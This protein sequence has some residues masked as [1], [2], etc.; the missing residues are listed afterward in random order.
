MRTE[1]DVILEHTQD[2]FTHSPWSLERFGSELLAPALAAAGLI[3]KV[4][5]GS[6]DELERHRK[7]WG[8]RISRV[9]HATQPFPLEWKWVW[10]SCLPAQYQA[11][12][13]RDLMLLAGSLAVRLPRLADGPQGGAQASLAIVLQEFGEFVQAAATPAQNGRYSEDDCPAAVDAMMREGVD[14]LS[15][16]LS[17]LKAASRGTGRQL[18]STVAVLL[19]LNRE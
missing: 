8:I 7:A 10:I 11:A 4:E 17:E 3:E 2:W 12:V 9:F 1:R 14:V 19:G 18:P 5:P 16:I 15:A 6:A 13:R